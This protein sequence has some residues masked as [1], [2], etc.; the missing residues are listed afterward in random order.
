MTVFLFGIG[1]FGYEIAIKIL[2]FFYIYVDFEVKFPLR[3][4]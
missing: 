1:N 3:T 4:W 2:L